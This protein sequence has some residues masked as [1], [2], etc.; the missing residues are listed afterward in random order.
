[1]PA[2]GHGRKLSGAFLSCWSKAHL[3]SFRTKFV[4]PQEF[5]P[6]SFALSRREVDGLGL[7]RGVEGAGPLADYFAF[8]KEAP[9]TVRAVDHGEFLG[10]LLLCLVGVHFEG[11]NPPCACD[12]LAILLD[13]LIFCVVG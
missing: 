10:V 3:S 4:N 6:F 1:M 13:R 7:L 2:A 9:C 8:G 12:L 5:L 11:D